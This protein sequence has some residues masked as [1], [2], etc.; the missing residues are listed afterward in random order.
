MP[1]IFLPAQARLCKRHRG[2][3]LGQVLCGPVVAKK[4]FTSLLLQDSLLRVCLQR[5]HLVCDPSRA[6]EVLKLRGAN[7]CGVLQVW[8]SLPVGLLSEFGQRAV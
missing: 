3:Q 7:A 2:E 1:L 8:A 4:L 6:L 5:L